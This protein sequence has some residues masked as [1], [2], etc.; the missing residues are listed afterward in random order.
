MHSSTSHSL[1]GFEIFTAVAVKSSVFW[2]ITL[3][4]LVNAINIS[5]EQFHLIF[6]IEE[7]AN[8]D[9]SMKEDE[10]NTC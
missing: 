3:C 5:A 1:A 6:R 8:Q 7:Q 9:T 10:S 4:S 2:D